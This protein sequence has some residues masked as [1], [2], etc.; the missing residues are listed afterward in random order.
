MA[1]CIDYGIDYPHA[2]V[3]CPAC[4]EQVTQQG[5]LKEMTRAND[6]KEKELGLRLSGELPEQLPPPKP[7]VVYTQPVKQQISNGG[8]DIEPRNTG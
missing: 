3:H 4:Y 7:R 6:L 2:A 1:K 5:M 8:I